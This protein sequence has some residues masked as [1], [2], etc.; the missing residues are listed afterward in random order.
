MTNEMVK[1]IYRSGQRGSRYIALLFLYPRRSVSLD[2]QRHALSRYSDLLR[3][4]WCGD[5]IPGGE[6]FR[7]SPDRPCGSLSPLYNGYRSVSRGKAARSSR[8]P[9]TQSSTQVKERLELY[10]YSHSAPSWP[11]LWRTLP[12][13]LTS[14]SVRCKTQ[15]KD[16][17]PVYTGICTAVKGCPSVAVDTHNISDTFCTNL[18]FCFSSAVCQLHGNPVIANTSFS[19]CVYVTESLLWQKERGSTWV[20][21]LVVKTVDYR[22]PKTHIYR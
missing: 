5:R 9:P 13:H 22:M 10:L 16:Q 1:F 8:W 7:T 12:L 17:T 3:A 4:G 20:D 19:Q 11:L 14:Q 15:H 18:L 2:S 6:I 21:T